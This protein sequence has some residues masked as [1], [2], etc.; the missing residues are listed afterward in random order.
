MY[1]KVIIMNKLCIA[2]Y[3]SDPNKAF[4]Y[5]TDAMRLARVTGNKKVLA[6]SHNNRRKTKLL[7]A[8]IS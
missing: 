1:S 4:E 3:Y 6:N 5:D 8:K 2:T 7:H